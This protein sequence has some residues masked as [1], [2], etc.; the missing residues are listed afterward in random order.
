M[1]RS[2]KSDKTVN[3]VYG[4]EFKKQLVERKLQL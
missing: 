3:P 2:G 4:G 1:S